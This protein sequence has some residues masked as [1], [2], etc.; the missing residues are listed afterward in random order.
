MNMIGMGGGDKPGMLD[1]DDFD[2]GDIEGGRGR[3]A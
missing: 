3:S 2:D 1:H